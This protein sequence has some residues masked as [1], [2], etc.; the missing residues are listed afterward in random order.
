MGRRKDEGDISLFVGIG[1]PNET[2]EEETVLV[3]KIEI[4]NQYYKLYGYTHPIY[5]FT[6]RLIY[7]HIWL[8]IY[9]V[10]CITFH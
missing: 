6:Y 9:F 3:S 2:S 1:K 10:N 7:S 8:Y 4:S 5:D